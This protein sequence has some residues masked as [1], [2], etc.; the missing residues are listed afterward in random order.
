[1]KLVFYGGGDKEDNAKLDSGLMS[2]FNKKKSLK[3]GFIPSS[4]LYGEMDFNDFVEQYSNYGV[5]KFINFPVDVSYNS[6]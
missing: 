2:L 4:S 6:F 5:Y 1:M 3:F